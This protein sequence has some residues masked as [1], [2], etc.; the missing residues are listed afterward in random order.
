MKQYWIAAI[1][2][3]AAVVF[4][5]CGSGPSETETKAAAAQQAKQQQQQ[6]TQKAEAERLAK[7]KAEQQ[8]L[9][10]EKAAADKKA[11]EEAKAAAAKKAAEERQAAIAAA[12]AKGV[13]AEDFSYDITRDGKGILIKAY[14]GLAT[15]VKIPAV[16]EGMPVT[17]LDAI[18]YDNTGITSVTIPD[19]VTFIG[20]GEEIISEDWE[21]E[22]KVYRGAF[23]GCTSLSS[24]TLSRN[25]KFVSF[26]M[27]YGC[28]SLRAVVIP[29]GVTEISMQAFE[30]C[31]ALA[32]VTLPASLTFIYSYAFYGCASLEAITLPDSLV[33]IGAGAFTGSG[34]TSIVLPKNL[35][36]LT[37]EFYDRNDVFPDKKQYESNDTGSIRTG[38]FQN[39]KKLKSATI[40]SS[41]LGLAQTFQGCESLTTLTINGNISF[42]NNRTEGYY[43]DS[44]GR[45]D[46]YME[47]DLGVFVDC[48]K[49]TT[50]NLGPK[51]TKIGNVD[52]LIDAGTFSIQTKVALARLR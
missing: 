28:T 39:C 12:N 13:T 7:E 38:V 16:I 31:A 26:R 27:F 21:E 37:E 11:A 3:S 42:G 8:R 14:N 4:A 20:Y 25:Q 15:I 45:G 9:A 32:S 24:V 1:V 30:N 43:E 49:L 35:K 48:N 44:G 22:K 29:N 6:Q 23:E 18:F 33:E 36:R 46:Y 17:E 40:E 52:V 10:K 2:L 5:A 47:I 50:V 19:S 51:V 34:L 41:G